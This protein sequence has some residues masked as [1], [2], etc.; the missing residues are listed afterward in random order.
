MIKSFFLLII[1]LIHK[2]FQF[3]SKFSSVS[4]Q[5]FFLRIFYHIYHRFFASLL[6]HFLCL[7]KFAILVNTFSH[8]SQSYLF[9]WWR[10]SLSFCKLFFNAMFSLQLIHPENL[11]YWGSSAMVVKSSSLQNYLS[12]I[13]NTIL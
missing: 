6:W 7:L 1:F 5:H 8:I 3:L 10:L 9:F 2:F 11:K 13:G 4:L 12:Q